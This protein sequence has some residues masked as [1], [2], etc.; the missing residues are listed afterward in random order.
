[1]TQQR[2]CVL[3]NG[4]LCCVSANRIEQIS[5]GF[6]SPRRKPSNIFLGSLPMDDETS[7][8]LLSRWKGGDEQAAALLFDRYVNQ[9]IALARNR[10]SE[11]MRRR[12]EPEDIVQS[13]YRSFFRRAGDDRYTLQNS[14][15]LWKLMAAITI[16]KLRGQVEFHTAKKRGVY[17]EE[18]I[19]A[20]HSN[21]GVG[22]Q[23]IAAEP[24]PQ[25]AAAVVEELES[26]MRR[27]DPLQRR[28][29]QFALQNLDT[30][31]IAAEVQRSAR[32]VRRSLQQIRDDLE[33]RLLDRIPP[34][35]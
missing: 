3:E 12:V 15:D 31:E 9:L 2:T 22:P 8:E 34:S 4:R 10:L 32:T 6:F 30:D 19:V 7:V 26:L 27:L 5:S 25:D 16:T 18:S 35:K 28:I 14:G 21:Y 23:A 11:P 13:A 33:K 24:S 1:M 29:L 17:S 20:S